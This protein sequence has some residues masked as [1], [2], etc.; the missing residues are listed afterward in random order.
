M[1][2]KDLQKQL[3]A[4]MSLGYSREEIVKIAT[5]APTIFRYTP[6][7]IRS[8]LNLIPVSKE[9]L[10]KID[11]TTSFIDSDEKNKKTR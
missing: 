3:E 10:S 4:L 8:I 9:D 5:K 2:N 11:A 1:E 7:E 6:E